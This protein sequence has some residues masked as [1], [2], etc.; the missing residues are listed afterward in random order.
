MT[1]SHSISGIAGA[2]KTESRNGPIHELE[3]ELDR[4]DHAIDQLEVQLSP[5]LRAPEVHTELAQQAQQA[6]R[7]SEL[8]NEWSARVTR[9]QTLCE[10]IDL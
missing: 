8:R 1:H 9:L 10:R 5:V 4:F 6:S 7:I 3:D 2:P